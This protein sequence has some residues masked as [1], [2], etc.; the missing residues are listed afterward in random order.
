MMKQPF[1]EHPINIDYVNHGK[2]FNGE[3]WYFFY[4]GNCKRNIW[5]DSKKCEFCGAILQ[6]LKIDKVE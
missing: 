1:P 4:C 6:D 3:N 5:G 2:V